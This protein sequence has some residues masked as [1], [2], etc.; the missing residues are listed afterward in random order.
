[1]TTLLCDR[2]FY[3]SLAEETAHFIASRISDLHAHCREH[4]SR[5]RSLCINFDDEM[6]YVLRCE[7][8]KQWQHR[9]QQC[10]TY[11]I[12][13]GLSRGQHLTFEDCSRSIETGIL[14]SE[15]LCRRSGSYREAKIADWFPTACG[16]PRP[17][18]RDLHWEYY[19]GDY[20]SVGHLEGVFT[21]QL[22]AYWE[23]YHQV[24]SD[25]LMEEEDV[26]C[27]GEGIGYTFERL[28]LDSCFTDA[29][30][31]GMLRAEAETRKV[32]HVAECVAFVV[33]GESYFTP[34]CLAWGNRSHVG[35]K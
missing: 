1:M 13:S 34:E 6:T 28:Q 7:T 20:F 10:K 22:Y 35:L 12:T 30:K 19:A 24:F 9:D 11:V 17:P 14:K 18:I 26:R 8:E 4:R 32:P 16:I 27:Y 29:V 3:D 23:K 33:Y 31:Q 2:E 21:P 5:L 15:D 25:R